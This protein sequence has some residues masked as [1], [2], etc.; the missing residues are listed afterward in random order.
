M[1]FQ[2]IVVDFLVLKKKKYAEKY[3]ENT[4]Y[5]IAIEFNVIEKNRAKK[6][7]WTPQTTTLKP[8]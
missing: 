5:L 7:F 2:S 6:A 3:Q 8:P 4:C 1:D